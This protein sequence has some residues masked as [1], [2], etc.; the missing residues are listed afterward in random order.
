MDLDIRPVDVL[1]GLAFKPVAT[2]LVLISLLAIGLCSTNTV[3]R[4]PGWCVA[5][6]C[7]SG[8]LWHA[9]ITTFRRLRN[10]PKYGSTLLQPGAF[11][12]VDRRGH[13]HLGQSPLDL[14]H[15]LARPWGLLAVGLKAVDARHRAGTR[16]MALEPADTEGLHPYPQCHQ[17][18]RTAHVFSFSSSDVD[19]SRSRQ[20]RLPATVPP[21]SWTLRLRALPVA[22][23][24]VLA[25][26]VKPLEPN[27][28]QPGTILVKFGREAGDELTPF[29]RHNRSKSLPSVL[30]RLTSC[31]PSHRAG[32]RWN[33]NAISAR[34]MSVPRAMCVRGTGLLPVESSM[35]TSSDSRMCGK[36]VVEDMVG[37]HAQVIRVSA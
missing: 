21:S 18:T 24:R 22:S 19:L 9:C 17:P 30:L 32:T 12:P 28:P 13:G 6:R 33:P 15:N 16:T 14:G 37:K 23:K 10:R 29:V 25:T 27:I 20:P 3:P 7:H 2:C 1:T 5:E 4:A 34:H 8:R 36:A 31:E 35:S 26:T 11:R